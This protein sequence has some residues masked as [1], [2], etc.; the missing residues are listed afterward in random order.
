[1]SS[2]RLLSTFR[3]VSHFSCKK[4]LNAR[5]C[6]FRSS[7]TLA[8]TETEITTGEHFDSTESV[9]WSPV[10][11][12]TGLS[13]LP[14]AARPPSA[15]LALL[16]SFPSLEPMSFTT[17]S[18][19]LLA[20]PFRRDI[21]WQAV[22]YENN[23]LRD[24]SHIFVPNRSELGYSKKKMAAQKGRGRARVGKAGSPIFNR[25]GKTF[26]PRNPDDS[27]RINR[28]VYNLA[29]RTAFSYTY[30]RGNLIVIDGQAELETFKSKAAQTVWSTHSWT[31][32][33]VLVIVSGDRKNLQA[34]L[35]KSQPL[36]R[37]AHMKD[38]DVRTLL[39]AKKILV[40]NDA[41]SYIFEKTTGRN[42]LD[43]ST[44]GEDFKI[45]S[46]RLNAI[47]RQ[48]KKAK[49]AKKAKTAEK[50]KKGEQ[51]KQADNTAKFS[52]A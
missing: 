25:G 21:L 42:Y 48:A 7:A 3:R 2:T 11:P 19:T 16:H 13:I 4:L 24:R 28:R 44:K 39:K 17:V 49:K 51:A 14:Y 46:K 33:P 6:Q 18:S 15:V 27:T 35:R 12:S 41:L 45:A 38:L 47:A 34:A 10:K 22:V 23:T 36:T 30:Q 26:G 43:E 40:E 20:L 8:H 31:D 52:K 1:M 5:D 29:L 9:A 50:T 37:I 32:L